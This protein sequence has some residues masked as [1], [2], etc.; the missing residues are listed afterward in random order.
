MK[1]PVGRTIEGAYGFAIS[2]F[3][4]IL[5]IAWFPVVAFFAVLVG[6]GVA[7]AP[8][9]RPLLNGTPDMGAI[10]P[11]IGLGLLAVILLI[12]VFSM[13]Q[14]GILR[15]A[16]HKHEGPAFFYFSLGAPVWR[17]I[18]ATFLVGVVFWLIGLAL[19]AIGF[20]AWN[21]TGNMSQ[22]GV[23]LLRSA[24][25]VVEVCAFFYIAVRLSFLLPA[26]VV[27]ED[28]IGIGRSWEL[29]AGSFWRIFVIYLACHIPL[30][31]VAGVVGL[32]LTGGQMNPHIEPGMTPQ[33]LFQAYIVASQAGG[34]IYLVFRILIT[35]ASAG[36][37]AGSQATAYLAVTERKDAE[38]A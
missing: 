37:S 34:I 36:L 5:G 31:I 6:L 26:V 32:L 20:I 17:L 11:I 15:Q 18:G 35:V 2:N 8:T 9:L 3:L 27:A 28:S 33:Q 10:G 12:V 7:M 30:G 19:V 29:S 1:I 24:V 38:F 23:W 14:V 4:N 16:L 25:I 22:P 21:V 13:I